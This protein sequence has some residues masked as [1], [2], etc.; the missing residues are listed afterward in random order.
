MEAGVADKVHRCTVK[1]VLNTAGYHYCRSRKKW[2]L[3]A[4]DLNARL[5]FCKSIC[6]R[7]LGQIFW[8]NHVAIYLNTKGFQ[9]KTQPLDQARARS[10][11]EWRTKKGGIK[12]GCTAKSTKEGCL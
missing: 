12:F 7:K 2:L 6:K 9:Y 8:N 4:A 5:D 10:A 1:R 3:R 11:S